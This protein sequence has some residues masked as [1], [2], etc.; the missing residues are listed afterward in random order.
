MNHLEYIKNQFRESAEVKNL[1]AENLSEEV[2]EIA[3]KV[4]EALK[5]GKKIFWCGNGGSA[6]DSQHL[7]TELISR[8]RFNRPA[9]PSIAL[10]TDT[11]FL[12]A[13][14]ND[15]DFD[16]IFSRQIEALGQAGDVL[17]GISTS[18][19]S[20]NILKAIKTA[21]SKEILTI[22]FSGKNGGT[23]KNIANFSLIVPSHET[24]RIQEGHITIGHIICD[25]I[26][27]S[28]YGNNN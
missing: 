12:T 5:K 23:M 13:H 8:L 28:L 19:N 2:D 26:E 11:S 14:T 27:K 21:K 18:G 1:M 6:A 10:T 25:L 20:K 17:I 15:F 4:V 22:V 24:Q 9:I 3:V 7:S 16:D